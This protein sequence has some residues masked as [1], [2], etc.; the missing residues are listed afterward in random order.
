MELLL[1]RKILTPEST[2]SDLLI[3][4]IFECHTLED[5]SRGLTQLM[6]VEDIKFFKEYGNTAIP[7]GR[8]KII[9]NYSN[10][11]KKY[12]PLLVNV[13]GYEG[14]R[15][16]TGNFPKD[17]H[18]C[19][20]PGLT[21]GENFINNS[22]K[23]FEAL[24]A[25]IKANLDAGDNVNITIVNAENMND[26][27]NSHQLSLEQELTA[28]YKPKVQNHIDITKPVSNV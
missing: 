25:K 6:S 17:T 22:F 11:F 24:Y 7:L 23:A 2:I 15:I 9:I 4:G 27:R 3:D 21:Y 8:Y 28:K 10:R 14:I 19:I 1:K 16:H 12:L 26:K 20:L 18:G 13:P 5:P